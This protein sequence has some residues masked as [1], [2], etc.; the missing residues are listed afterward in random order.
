MTREEL[1]KYLDLDTEGLDEHLMEQAKLYEQAAE[2]VANSENA[3][4]VKRLEL[5]ELIAA[6]DK[7]VRATAEAAKEKIT[8]AAVKAEI[9]TDR[10]VMALQRKVLELEHQSGLWKAMERSFS[11]RADMLKK[12]VDLHLRT[13][14]GYSLEHSTGQARGNLVATTAEK[15][16]ADATAVRRKRLEDK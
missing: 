9:A 13:A 3:L 10:D 8:E 11:Q 4:K 5:E 16:R 2:A 15:N 7:D 14:Y 12:L 6:T 1:R